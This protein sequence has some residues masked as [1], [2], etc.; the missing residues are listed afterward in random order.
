M[1]LNIAKELAELQKMAVRDLRVRYVEVF[2]EETHARN[3]AWIIK[4]I[5]WRLQS[6]VEGDLT[7]R[8]RRRAIELAND[9]D[10]RLIPPPA[11][12]F[13]AD[14]T[15]PTSSDTLKV[16]S[17]QQ[18]PPPGTILTRNYKGH[19][20]QVQVL[21]QGFEFEGEVYKTLSAAAKHI[22]GQHCSGYAFFRLGQEKS[23]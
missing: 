21:P 20:L 2:G 4:R 23:K 5:V 8:A 1:A 22:T 15:Q 6:Q 10:I 17:K 13:P 16:S 3:K 7:E 18:L 11:N 9:A 12:T 14:S 19:T